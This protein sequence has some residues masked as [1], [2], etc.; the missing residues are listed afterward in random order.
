MMRY[1]YWI[2]CSCML[3]ISLPVNAGS[4]A[5]DRSDTYVSPDAITVF[6]D[7]ARVHRRKI[8][9][10]EK[11]ST[12]VVFGGLPVF[13]DPA[14]VRARVIG[15]EGMILGVRMEREFHL[16]AV[17]EKVRVSLAEIQK[18]DDQLDANGSRTEE[19]DRALVVTQRLALLVEDSI[20][21]VRGTHLLG[22]STAV[23]V[24]EAQQWVSDRQL[25]L[26]L[27]KDRLEQLNTAIKKM[28]QD[29]FHDLDLERGAQSL[30]TWEAT[31]LLQTQEEGAATVE[32]AHDVFSAQW[33]PI[34]VASL[35]DSEGQVRWESR[36]EVSQ[37]SGEDWN[38]VQ[39]TLS[40]ARSSLGL[41]PPALVPMRVSAIKKGPER[42][43]GVFDAPVDSVV[44][45]STVEEY[46][47]DSILGEGEVEAGIEDLSG[48]KVTSGF[49]PVHFEILA[50]AS[51]PGG[52]SIHA[53]TI[54]EQILSAELDYQS[55]PL[56]S[57]HVFRRASLVNTSKAPFLAGI[58]RCF[59]DGA[60]VGDGSVQRIAQGQEFTQHFGSEGRI[61]V[62]KE[63]IE[64]RSVAASSFSKSV[65]L[66]KAY[67]FTIRSMI[68]DPISVQL[69][70]RIPVS[71]VE[72]AAVELGSETEPE[73]KVDTD[74]IARW[75]VSLTKGQQQVVVLQWVAT[76]SQEDE[77]IL[78]RLR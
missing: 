51:I 64:D 46:S 45:T 36:A 22:G 15:V 60:Y 69:V 39:L 4:S 77:V 53:V 44:V 30:T 58:V 65:K 38:D 52:G 68:S 13:I 61:V 74:G 26:T 67:R 49:G 14:S 42:S 66:V 6:E 1:M 23:Q 21:A 27:E 48:A 78:E 35:D 70:D 5:G 19:L 75:E 55:V 62:R 28:R 11:G 10:V 29:L 47:E 54:T 63:E 24:V 76:V 18:L 32:L 8:I 25:E 9:D 31:V 50:P 20:S 7:R 40:T 43:L 3:S 41:T 71:S 17:E 73:P 34:H 72:S 56:L 33:I 12:E 37:Q 16:E 2:I 59:R 57:P